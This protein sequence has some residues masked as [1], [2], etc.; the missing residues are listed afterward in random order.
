MHTFN[1]TAYPYPTTRHLPQLPRADQLL[2]IMAEQQ[3]KA[4]IVAL[5]ATFGLEN[6]GGLNLKGFVY[7]GHATQ[8]TI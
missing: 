5:L 3:Y 8:M 2:E 7:V 4:K 6:T 1:P